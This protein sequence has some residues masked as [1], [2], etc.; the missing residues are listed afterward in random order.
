[1]RGGVN[2]MLET[3]NVNSAM[4]KRNEPK[5]RGETTEGKK[6]VKRIGWDRQG[7][8]SGTVGDVVQLRKKR[9]IVKVTARRWQNWS[10]KNTVRRRSSWLATNLPGSDGKGERHIEGLCPWSQG[11]KKGKSEV[12]LVRKKKR[13][14][15]AG[16][17][18]SKKIAKRPFF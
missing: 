18:Q 15:E 1:M 2:V 9:L 11:K 8:R 12:R 16:P 4:K 3:T 5:K 6:I 7:Y 14:K 13:E 17:E 10:G